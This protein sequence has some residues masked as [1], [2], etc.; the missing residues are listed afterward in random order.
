VLRLL[1]AFI[2]YFYLLA[3]R[4]HRSNWYS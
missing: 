1:F 2:D 3:I 4:Y